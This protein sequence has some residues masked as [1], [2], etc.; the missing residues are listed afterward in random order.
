MPTCKLCCTKLEKKHLRRDGS[1]L[2]PE[3]GQIYWKVALDKA[4]AEE[5]SFEP[6]I[7]SRRRARAVIR[8][9]L[10]RA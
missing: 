2:C 8:P 6:F 1:L 10:R 4:V 9:S 7:Q 3:C 5:S